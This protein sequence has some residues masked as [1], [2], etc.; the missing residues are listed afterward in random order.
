[1]MASVAG[2][3]ASALY[4]LA[5]EQNQ[6]KLVEQ[7]M[8]QLQ[9]MFDGSEDMRRLVRSPVFSADEQGKALDAVMG[10]AQIGG[11]TAN[12][13]K[14]IARNRRLFVLPEMI[15]NFHKLVAQGRGEMQAE[16]VSAVAL[17][18]AQMQL[19][20]DTLKASAGKDVSITSRVDPALLGGLV[21]KIGSRMIDSSI[22]TK[23]NSLKIAMKEVG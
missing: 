21:V 14:L 22:A 16:V 18:D 4:D 9:S 11:L 7:G 2:R 13:V 6:V 20:K 8:T 15:R 3:Y 1:M 5:T 12:F 17:N 10:K 23:L 19:L